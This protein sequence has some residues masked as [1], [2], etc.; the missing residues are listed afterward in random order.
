M[1]KAIE[2]G[3]APYA[4]DDL[5][6]L[7]GVMARTG[8]AE[9]ALELLGLALH[10]PAIWDETRSTIESLLTDLRAKLPPDA[11]EAALGRGQSLELETV[12]AEILERH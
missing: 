2:I 3:G 4:L 10:H 1:H 7:A 12:V 9:R 6:C 11:I 5:A 8:Q